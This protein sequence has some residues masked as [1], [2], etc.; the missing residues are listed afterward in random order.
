MD[1]LSN[2]NMVWMTKIQLSFGKSIFWI[3]IQLF[4]ANFQFPL[5][6]RWYIDKTNIKKTYQGDVENRRTDN[7]TDT[8]IILNVIINFNY[9]YI[10]YHD[11]WTIMNMHIQY[12]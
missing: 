3:K 6:P 8:D 7:T 4:L 5:I 12:P 1:R 9:K 10:K 11:I 2:V